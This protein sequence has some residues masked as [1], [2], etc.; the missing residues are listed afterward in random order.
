[1]LSP[2]PRHGRRATQSPHRPLWSHCDPGGGGGVDTLRMGTPP[3]KGHS[4]MGPYLVAQ[5]GK[6]FLLAIQEDLA[7]RLLHPKDA[8]CANGDLGGLSTG[9]EDGGGEDV[10]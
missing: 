3:S 2:K 4:E 6:W 5:V 7:G 10:L 1:M 9:M 8:Q